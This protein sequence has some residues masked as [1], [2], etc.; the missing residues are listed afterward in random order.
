MGLSDWDISGSGGQAI[1]DDG[2][3]MRC[4]LSGSK[5]MLWN[6]RNDLDD[7]EVI[8]KIRSGVNSNTRGGVTL[9]SNESGLTSYRMDIYGPRTY[10][11]RKIVN[12]TPTTLATAVSGQPYN[13]Y[14]KIRFRVDG[15]QL[16]VEEYLSGEWELVC[17]IEDT[18][19]AVTSGFAGI[20]GS[21]VS[22]SYYMSFDDVEVSEKQ[23]V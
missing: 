22:T 10:Y 6:G 7:S 5:L 21:S 20:F 19:E 23:V 18:S 4:K 1:I 13:V 2:G 14:L 9:R 17:V 11:V 12:G 3:S 16:S 8:T 15:F